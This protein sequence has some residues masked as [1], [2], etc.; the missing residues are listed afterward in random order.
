MVLLPHAEH[1]VARLLAALDIPDRLDHLVELVAAVDHRP[2]LTR[3]DQ[4]P[5]ENEILLAIAPDAERRTPTPDEPRDECEER[6]LVHEPEVHR[7]VDP[8]GI[9]RAPAAAERVLAN[10]VE[11]HV[12][13]YAVLREVLTEAIEDVPR[14]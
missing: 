3:L 4:L 1:D 9:Q 14:A 5:D 13:G 12:V 11:D 8:G 6:H 2:V 7:D 10:R